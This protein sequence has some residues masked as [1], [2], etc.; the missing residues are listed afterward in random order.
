M[1]MP[2]IIIVGDIQQFLPKKYVSEPESDNVLRQT[3]LQ[4][5]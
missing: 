2:T 1:T 4:K 5:K 3:K